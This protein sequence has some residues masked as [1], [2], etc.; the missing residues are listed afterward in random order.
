MPNILETIA[1]WAACIIKR[2]KAGNLAISRKQLTLKA[3]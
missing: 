3:R 1:E 2:E